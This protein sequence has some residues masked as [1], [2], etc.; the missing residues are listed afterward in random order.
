MPLVLILIAAAL[1]LPL[2]LAKGGHNGATL[3]GVLI[4]IVAIVTTILTS[5]SGRNSK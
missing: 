2:A 3:A 4:V 5:P 1:L